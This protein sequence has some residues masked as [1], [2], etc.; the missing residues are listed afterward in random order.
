L[1]NR[2]CY[3]SE[4]E[5]LRNTS[6]IVEEARNKEKFFILLDKIAVDDPVFLSEMMATFSSGRIDPT[7]FNDLLEES[8]FE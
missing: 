3:I 5:R 6:N 4:K 1:N 7:I 8:Y 2:N